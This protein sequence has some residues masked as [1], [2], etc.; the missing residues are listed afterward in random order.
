MAG[1]DFVFVPKCA[2]LPA[3]NTGQLFGGVI[4]AL[5]NYLLIRQLRI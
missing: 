1:W 5:H 2:I 4:F 3:G